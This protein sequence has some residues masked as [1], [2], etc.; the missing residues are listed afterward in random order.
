MS[1]KVKAK[2]TVLQ[3]GELKGQTRFILQ[4]E[5][6]NTLAESKV[7]KEASLRS[8]LSKGVIKS[9]WDAIGDVV[10]SWAT[11][12][13]SVAIPGLG[14]MRFGIR[15][16]S[17]GKVEDVS[18]NLITTRRVIFVPSVDIKKELAGTNIS[19]TCYNAEGKVITNVNSADNKEIEDNDTV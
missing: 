4:P 15:A 2:E 6:Y 5:R 10:A 1:I 8:G 17:V 18:T 14:H 12:G 19:I 7:V 9:A 11:E 13:H 3:I 16:T